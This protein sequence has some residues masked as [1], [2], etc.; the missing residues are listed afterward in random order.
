MAALTIS[1]PKVLTVADFTGTVTVGNS[2]GGTTT[3][4]AT[5]MVRPT[6]WNSVH[7]ATFSLSAADVASFLTIGNGLDVT[8]ATSGITLAVDPTEFLTVSG[9]GLSMSTNAG[10]V[11]IST[12]PSATGQFFEPFPFANSNSVSMTYSADQWAFDPFAVPFGLISGRFHIFNNRDASHFSNTISANTTS[13]G[14]YSV[15]AEFRNL[16][17]IYSM[18]PNGTAITSVWTGGA[19]ISA[20]QS[21][22]FA[23]ATSGITVSN[24]LTIGMLTGIDE[25]GGSSTATKTTSGTFSTGTTSMNATAVNSLIT[26]AINWFTASCMDMVP[27]ASTLSPGIYWLGYM[28]DTTIGGGGTT[29]VNR[30]SAGTWFNDRQSRYGILDVN[31]S[32]FKR[33]GGATSANSGSMGVPY[34]GFSFN[35]TSAAPIGI[36][37]ANLQHTTRRIYWNYVQSNA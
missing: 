18:Q 17:A 24:Y 1:H 7:A 6:D 37:S 13:L 34:H 10:S 4:R 15:T 26:G 3:Q 35:T 25:T 22:T 5:D 20:T 36:L 19:G 33:I 9:G 16:L 14:A 2:S 8:T 21:Q 23:G 28:H 11:T 31:V 12:T 32:N 27:F 29:D 30:T